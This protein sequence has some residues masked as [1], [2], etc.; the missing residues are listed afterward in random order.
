MLRRRIH[1]SLRDLIVILGGVLASGPA[2]V[3]GNGFI[4]S[5]PPPDQAEGEIREP[6]LPRITHRPIEQWIPFS[7]ASQRLDIAINDLVA[8][9]AIEQVFVNRCGRQ[10]E[11]TYLF[12][13]PESAAVHNFTMWMNEREVTAELLDAA[14]ARE[15]YQSIVNRMKDPALLEVVGCGLIQA[16]VFPIPPGG[17][18]RIKLKYS[19]LLR[20][21]A[22]LVAYRFPLGRGPAGN[23]PIERFSLRAMIQTAQPLSSIY[24]PSY[25]CS[26]DRR[27][28]REAVVGLETRLLQADNDFQLFF[29]TGSE[30]FG[31]ALLTY[32]PY[33]EDGFFMARISPRIGGHD[34]P[35]MPKNICFVLDTSGSM[36]D[37]DKIAQAKKALKWCLTTL[38]KEDRFNLITFATEVRPFRPDW[39]RAG[40][41][42]VTAAKS[43]V[44]GLSAVGGT[45]INAAMQQA[46]ALNPSKIKSSQDTGFGAETWRKNPYFIVFITDGEPTVGVTAPEQIL[47]NLAEADTANEARVF[48]LGVGYQVNTKLLDRMADDHGGARDYVT[49]TEDLELKISAFYTKLAHPVLSGLK[50]AIEGVSTNDVYPKV[51]P[52]LFK[53]SELVIVGRF[54][55]VTSSTQSIRLTGLKRGD[56]K[57]YVYDCR[58]PSEVQ[59]GNDFLARIWAM[60]KIGYL[61]DAL[62]LHGDNK[63]LKDEVIRL[64]KLYGIMT[65][66]T[67]FL[68]MED[69]QQAVRGGRAAVGPRSMAPAMD[70]MFKLKGGEMRRAAAG[71]EAAQGEDSVTQSQG[72]A[73][74]RGA[75]AS[76]PAKLLYDIKESNRTADGTQLM[77]FIGDKTFY[78]E[79][80]RWVDASYDGKAKTR[81][82][83]LFSKEYYDFIAANAAVGR[84]LSQ[85]DQ[86]VLCWAGQ[87]YETAP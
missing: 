79:N 20:G 29:G 69:E 86:V 73:R 30:P 60:C 52:D 14:K 37:D 5:P 50:L 8:E 58:F 54:G 16:K 23:R 17:E 63:E 76:A 35:A 11:G 59:P 34:E 81:K 49:P 31:L 55:A 68:I 80:G 45:D 27:G 39:S 42:A 13:I 26:V 40:E 61:L 56:L 25:V 47:K 7:I 71:Q 32:R 77:N 70:G 53:G 85:G 62:R 1:A 4:I 43:F 78:Q 22:G 51:L 36:A 9:T 72:N 24:C 21:D 67:S 74:L 3:M 15:I 6:R 33:G 28:D 83:R 38:G 12:P 84:Y 64:S 87:V 44:D 10:V 41:D 82:L 2:V 65:P 66:Y 18:C 57:S 75:P 19:E 46:I 48:V